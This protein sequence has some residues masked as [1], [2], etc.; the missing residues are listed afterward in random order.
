MS[1]LMEF[2]WGVIQQGLVKQ[3]DKKKEFK[4]DERFYSPNK[5]DGNFQGVIRFLPPKTNSGLPIVKVYNHNFEMNGKYF[6]E[7]CLTTIGKACP[8]CAA[9]KIAWDSG[10]EELARR[11]KR[12]ITYFSNII[13]IR[14][15][16]KEENEGKVFLFRY[17]EKIHNIIMEAVAPS[18]VD[19]KPINVFDY[20]KGCD[21]KLNLYTE[22][23]SNKYNNKKDK[24]TQFDKCKFKNS[25]ELFDGNE[26]KILKIHEQ[27]YELDDFLSASNFKTY[28][29]LD[30]K[31]QKISGAVSKTEIL[32]PVKE[33][34]LLSVE[35][36]E[37]KKIDIQPEKVKIN[38]EKEEIK[39]KEVEE[40]DLN[41][42]D[43]DDDFIKKIQ[44]SK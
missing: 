40:L 21:F 43:D 31:F 10:Q 11:R 5:K 12:R 19:E 13:V 30:I 23:V 44:E 28:E 6:V 14:D 41:M 18:D 7:N 15:S 1:K 4:K 32:L 25:T 35:I 38:L 9:N 24:F 37:D 27:L 29:E 33:K 42:I 3:Q 34:T 22:E 2:D 26:E 17:G 36:K 39:E 20:L 8:V 16:E